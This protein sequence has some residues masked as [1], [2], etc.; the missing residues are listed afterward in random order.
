MTPIISVIIPTYNYG[1]FIRHAIDSVRRQTLASVQIVVVDDGST[2]NTAE[3]FATTEFVDVK[4]VRQDN[5][6]LAGA[7]NTGIA[8]ADGEH[9]FFL[10][11]DDALHEKAL[12]TALQC[13]NDHG[14]DCA[15]V[16]CRPA[17]RVL[18]VETGEERV[19]EPEEFN[20]QCSEPVEVLWRD[21]MLASRFPPSVLVRRD[22]LRSCGGFDES[23]SRMGCED[24][25]MW[26]RVARHHRIWMVPQRLVTV[27]FHGS[28]MSGSPEKQVPGIRKCLDKARADSA[29]PWWHLGFWMRVRSSFH[30]TVAML[31]WDAGALHQALGHQLKG[32]LSYP[33]PG[34]SG[35]LKRPH[36]WRVRRL[37]VMVREMAI[38]R[39]SQRGGGK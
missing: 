9:V 19:F 28:N 6:G 29:M 33:F 27:T 31:Y 2:D 1:R 7:R 26:L 10:D 23:F 20:Q 36:L 30:C 15:M 21:L 14:V 8:T 25:D 3:M 5:K 24:R 38:G 34:L 37:W 17:V 39:A 32:L 4:Y 18:N 35:E 12:E 13:M 22:V 11:A 16:A